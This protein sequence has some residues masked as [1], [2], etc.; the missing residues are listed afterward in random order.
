[1]TNLERIC[2]LLPCAHCHE[3]IGNR[4]FRKDSCSF[5][6]YHLACYEPA[7]AVTVM[8]EEAAEITP[9]LYEKLRL[10]LPL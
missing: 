10:C 5:N 1:M 7:T 4:P 6:V 8:I 9:E 2:R 3:Q